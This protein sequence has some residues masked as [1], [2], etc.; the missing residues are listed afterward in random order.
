M[1]RAKETVFAEQR[2]GEIAESVRTDGQITVLEMSEKY[3]VSPATIRAD[4]TV[5]EE[6]GL[7][8]RT[9]GGAI[10]AES[11][12]GL[13]Q[14]SA[15]KEAQHVR[16]KQ[17]IAK[18]AAALIEPGDVIALDTGTTTRELANVL[19]GMSGITV[20]TNDIRIATVLSANEH[21]TLILLGGSV[22]PGFQC[23][24]GALTEDHLG[25]IYT[26]K[27]FI[28]ANGMSTARGLSTP[29]IET[30]KIKHRLITN[31]GKVIAMV[32]SSKIGNEALCRFASMNEI[33]TL[34]TDPAAPQSF[35]AEAERAGV[36]V[37][38][39]G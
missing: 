2:R 16:E 13:E 32:D 34:I 5:L 30:G 18:C 28:A 27:A 22:R 23:T 36:E 19:L 4:L 33:H 6:K 35:L 20:V 15:E 11:R 3:G 31:T 8:R 26:D 17:A 21:I 37:I 29:H 7:L 1:N 10:R 9:H 24:L 14:T 39:A 25:Q 38:V 12:A